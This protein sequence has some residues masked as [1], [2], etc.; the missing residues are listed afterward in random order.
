MNAGRNELCPC[1]SGKK[2]K[3]CCLREDDALATGAAVRGIKSAEIQL[4]HFATATYG[5]TASTMLGRSSR[6]SSRHVD[7]GDLGDADSFPVITTGGRGV[8][9]IGCWR[10]CFSTRTEGICGGEGASS[11]LCARSFDVLRFSWTSPRC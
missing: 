10:R 2:Y 1:G 7:I 11:R 9:N 6:T 4:G 5:G 8:R 3:K